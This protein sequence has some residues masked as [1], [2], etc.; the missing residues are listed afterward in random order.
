M[1]R[2]RRAGR[3]ALAAFLVPLAIAVSAPAAARDDAAA[4]RKAREALAAFD[5]GEYETALGLYRT[6]HRL[7]PLAAISFAEARCLEVLRRWNEALAVANRALTER[8]GA[9]LATRLKQKI[10][11]YHDRLKVGRLSV[12]ATPAGAEVLVDGT[13]VGRVPLEPLEVA[14]GPHR[15]TVRVSANSEATQ[16]VI[17]P[18]GGEAAVEMVLREPAGR[19]AVRVGAPGA[20]VFVDGRFVGPAPA[21]AEGLQP[22]SHRVEARIPGRAPVVDVVDVGDGETASVVLAGRPASA[23]AWYRSALGWSLAGLGVAGLA[24][25]GAL[26]GVATARREDVQSSLAA[27]RAAGPGAPVGTSQQGLRSRWESADTLSTWGYVA[28]GVGAAAV[29]GSVVAFVAHR[30]PGTVETRSVVV[31]AC[32]ADACGV[33]VSA[34]F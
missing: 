22:G 20:E 3:S 11:H 23:D 10:A 33:V 12:K 6:A 16:Q 27:G 14:A 34:G 2:G 18:G 31:P 5:A 17:V 26:V 29:A 24:T 30:P 28:I 1:T 32:G 7:A 19:I 25:G 9:D 4:A 8:P 13:A 21:V 15:V